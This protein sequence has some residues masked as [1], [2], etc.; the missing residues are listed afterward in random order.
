MQLLDSVEKS[1]FLGR[2]LLLWLWFESEVLE[3]ERALGGESVVLVLERSIALSSGKEK[4]RIVG[5]TPSATDEARSSVR[6]GKLPDTCTFRI[7]RGEE[8][9]AFTLKGETLAVSGVALPVHL[10]DEKHEQFYERMRLLEELEAMIEELNG[11]FLTLRLGPAW[12][13]A[14][15]PA[16][17]AWVQ[18]DELDVEAYRRARADALRRPKRKG[19]AQASATV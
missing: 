3:G 17:L 11:E 16:L 2:E 10:R 9:F 7:T 6:I 5:R 12:H 1:R 19:A 15:V 4:T 13:E 8:E 14:V 18:G